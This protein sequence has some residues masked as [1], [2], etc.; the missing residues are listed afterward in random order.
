LTPVAVVLVKPPYRSDGTSC[1][2]RQVV[3][4]NKVF[5]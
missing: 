2:C 1:T 3:S 5:E 4:H